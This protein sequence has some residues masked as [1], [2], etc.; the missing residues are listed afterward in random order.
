[1]GFYEDNLIYCSDFYRGFLSEPELLDSKQKKAPLSLDP[2]GM[3]ETPRSCTITDDDDLFK[4]FGPIDGP[5]FKSY[6][7]SIA[8]LEEL[9]NDQDFC[10]DLLA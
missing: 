1:M 10:A 7:D 6:L 3:F 5:V 9:L 2:L 4:A 8:R